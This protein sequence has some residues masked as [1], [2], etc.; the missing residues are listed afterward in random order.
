MNVKDLYEYL[1]KALKKYPEIA[2]YTV[3]I[4]YDS[5]Y[6]WVSPTDE[7]LL[8]MKDDEECVLAIRSDDDNSENYYDTECDYFLIYKSSLSGTEDKD[9]RSV[10]LSNTNMNISDFDSVY[11]QTVCD[12]IITAI[13]NAK[14]NCETTVDFQAIGKQNCTFVEKFLE[15]HNINYWVTSDNTGRYIITILV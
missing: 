7:D 6:G 15:E 2:N 1:G 13:F 11:V 12:S 3:N 10:C 8:F 4:N 5:G 9:R 14:A